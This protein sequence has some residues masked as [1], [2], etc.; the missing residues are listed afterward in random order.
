MRGGG[1]GGYRKNEASVAVDLLRRGLTLQQGD[2]FAQ[3]LQAVVSELVE[4]AVPAVVGP[5]L[6]VDAWTA[7]RVAARR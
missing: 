1:L 7:L 3:L 5:W 6:G 4:R 2:R